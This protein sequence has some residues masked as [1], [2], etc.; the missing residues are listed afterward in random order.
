MVGPCRLSFVLSFFLISSSSSAEIFHITKVKKDANIPF[1]ERFV[2]FTHHIVVSPMPIL[3][4]RDQISV[5]VNEGF[6]LYLVEPNPHRKARVPFAGEV[7]RIDRFAVVVMPSSWDP[8]E[9]E[10]LSRDFFVKVDN[11]LHPGSVVQPS[12]P[13]IPE[14]S[15][16]DRGLSNVSIDG[17]YIK[18][19]I[20]EIS[21]ARTIVIG[22]SQVTI[23]ERGSA[24]GRSM[25]RS[26]LRSAYESMGYRVSEQSYKNSWGNTGVNLVAEKPG[27]DASKVLVLSCHYD[28]ASNAGADDNGSGMAALLS[29]A[30]S[31]KDQDFSATIRFAYFDQEEKG[32]VGSSAYAKELSGNNQMGSI[33][34]VFNLDML[35]YDGN[36]DYKFH[37]IDCDENTSSTLTSIVLDE[38]TNQN[39]SIRNNKAC[40][41]RS[42]H[43]TFWKYNVP[44]VMISE[45]YFGDDYNPCYH[46]SCDLFDKINFD[47]VEQIARAVAGSVIR[48]AGR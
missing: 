37:V 5:E 30:R 11:M 44:S 7:G 23:K 3:Q 42:D 32:L 28:S 41:D 13:E 27:S 14:P 43:A 20:E 45:D 18:R 19:V 6:E 34:G 46:K 26:Y 36:K 29:I 22:G 16:A 48:V 38:I 31:I 35:G 15:P 1:Y 17:A 40:T 8:S 21:G 9:D 33:I 12:P 4:A 39:L 47:Y 24:S 10:E 2:T 25:T